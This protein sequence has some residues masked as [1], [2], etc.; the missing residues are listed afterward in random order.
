MRR[1]YVDVSDFRAPYDSPTLQLTGLGA[2]VIPS[3]WPVGRSYVDV[4]RFRAPYQDGYF[5][6][7]QLFGLGSTVE[8]V[9]TPAPASCPLGF[10]AGLGVGSMVGLGF[11]LV[12][13]A[14]DR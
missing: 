13:R 7:N 10:L 6:N 8:T 14:L 12:K 2:A 3:N 4:S 11:I 9:E 1:A 5:Q